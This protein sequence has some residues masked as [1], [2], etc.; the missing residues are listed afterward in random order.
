MVVVEANDDN[1]FCVDCKHSAGGNFLLTWWKRLTK[2]ADMEC[3]K[4]VMV[5][6]KTNLITGKIIVIKSNLPLCR[7]RRDSSYQCGEKGRDWVPYS[8]HKMFL[9]IKRT[10]NNDQTD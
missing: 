5:S 9:Y 2:N 4:D 7:D 6:S 1:V 3:T 8:K 10:G